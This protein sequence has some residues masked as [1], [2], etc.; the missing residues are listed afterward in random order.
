MNDWGSFN[1]YVESSSVFFPYKLL[2]VT[3]F[4]LH[5]NVLKVV[6]NILDYTGLWNNRTEYIIYVFF[7]C[8]CTS[9]VL[10]SVCKQKGMANLHI[11]GTFSF[12]I[13]KVLIPSTASPSPGIGALSPSEQYWKLSFDVG[14][15]VS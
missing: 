15:T 6:D 12:V 13:D 11:T 8:R 14:Y 5:S 4:Y 10:T 9:A 3:Q 1:L 7:F 2:R